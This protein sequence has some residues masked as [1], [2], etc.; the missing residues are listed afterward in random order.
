M[1]SRTRF[2]GTLVLAASIAAP[3]AQAE[4]P[5]DR[6][7]TRGPGAVSAEQAAIATRP[8]DR[9]GLRGPGAATSTEAAPT[10]TR[11]DDRAGRRGPGA[12][13]T[14]TTLRPDDR[15]GTRGPGALTTFAAQPGSTGFDWNDAFIG[16]L[17]GLSTALLLTGGLL[18]LASR[19]DPNRS[20]A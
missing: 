7:G 14:L 6:S 10:V 19:R 18:V 3:V 2:F 17:V 12:V 20:F 13:S 4:R 1:R 8:D 5:D 16:G 15:D 11:P 9:A